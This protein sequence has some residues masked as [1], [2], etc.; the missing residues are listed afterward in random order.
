[1]RTSRITSTFFTVRARWVKFQMSDFER[2]IGI[3]ESIAKELRNKIVATTAKA[4]ATHDAIRV[5]YW[6]EGLKQRT[7]IETPYGLELHF[8]GEAFKRNTD[9]TIRHYPNKW[10]GY[11]RNL[12][13]PKKKTLAR[14]ERLAPGSTHDLEH[15]LW[16]LIRELDQGHTPEYDRLLK[17]LSVDILKVLFSSCQSGFSIYSGRVK[18][19]QILLD[20][21]ER[22]AS[23]DA[24][25]GLIALMLEAV[26]R[27]EDEFLLRAAQSIHNVLLMV[28]I[29]LA[30]RKVADQV[31]NWIVDK[32]LPLG[33]PPNLKFAMSSK[34]YIEASAYLNLMVYQN[35][36]RKGRDLTWPQRV[37]VMSQLINGRMSYDVYYAM[38]PKY[39]LVTESS[40][41]CTQ[42][43]HK[44]KRHLALREWGWSIIKSGEIA[45][46]PPVDLALGFIE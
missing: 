6:Y 37:K 5:A 12:T 14:V 10:S 31:V 15:P 1:M 45:H 8:E 2:I 11:E 35:S 33:A 28:T 42:A 21:L 22:R 20:K 18:S 46:F 19:T 27:K 29:E 13:T 44:F 30:S 39:D 25:T 3:Y 43:L 16:D 34:D 9:G 40:K 24:L 26:G 32:I 23:L 38:R 36:K 7:G 4:R 41:V 17:S